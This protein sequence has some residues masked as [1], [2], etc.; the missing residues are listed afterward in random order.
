[1]NQDRSPE[2]P[3]LADARVE[4]SDGKYHYTF[5]PEVFYIPSKELT[6]VEE[7]IITALGNGLGGLVV[8]LRAINNAGYLGL[9]IDQRAKAES[10]TQAFDILRN[11]GIAD[12][13]ITTEDYQK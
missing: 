12:L 5:T 13:R 2:G 4:L 10:V 9:V 3:R 6:Q 8:H 7:Q 1:M 11:A